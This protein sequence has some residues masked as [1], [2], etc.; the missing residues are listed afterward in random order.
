M[1]LVHG[2]VTAD[3]YQPRPLSR[4]L[5]QRDHI[6]GAI[7]IA[8]PVG[9]LIRAPE[10]GEVFYWASFR[11]AV[12]QVWPEQPMI[13]GQL[14]TF[15]NYFYDMFGG[16]IVVRNAPRTRTHIITHIWLNQMFNKGFTQTVHTAEERETKRFAIFGIYSVPKQVRENEIIGYVGNAGYSTGPHVHWEIHRGLR[17]NRWEHRINPGVSNE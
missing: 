3:F 10:S 1:K 15:C 12:G 6:H 2:T 4:P 9:T 11:Q 5:D 8:A 16:V 14:F 13:N 17:W 7:D